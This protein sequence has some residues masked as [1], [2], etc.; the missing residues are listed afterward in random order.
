MGSV[1]GIVLKSLNGFLALLCLWGLTA[2]E[3][4]KEIKPLEGEASKEEVHETLPGEIPTPLPDEVR[5]PL[6]DEIPETPSGEDHATL[7]VVYNLNGVSGN[8]FNFYYRD[9]NKAL[10]KT[11][12]T[13]RIKTEDALIRLELFNK[14]VGEVVVC[15]EGIP[16]NCANLRTKGIISVE[17]NK[18]FIAM[19]SVQKTD[20]RQASQCHP[21][22]VKLWQGDPLTQAAFQFRL[23]SGPRHFC[24]R[25]PFN[26]GNFEN[27]FRASIINENSCVGAPTIMK[28]TT[29]LGQ[30]RTC[31]MRQS[32]CTLMEGTSDKP[33]VKDDNG[34]P[35]ILAEGEYAIEMSAGENLHRTPECD[36]H[37]LA[38]EIK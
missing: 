16:Q 28:I 1:A 22:A 27:R 34:N 17:K 3:E 20:A 31:E 33:N 6:P 21:S 15:E 26:G 37:N 18:T 8:D 25:A 12:F 30:I 11:D 4:I 35:M 38:V 9:L 13:M 2:C 10:I 24:A 36:L 32:S 19:V 29:P 5:Q 14:A 23:L 7:K